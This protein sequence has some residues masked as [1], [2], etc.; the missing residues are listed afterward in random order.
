M[1]LRREARTA[2]AAAGRRPRRRWGQHFLCDPRVV[3][4][5]VAL[6]E[7]DPESAVLEI[8]PGLGALSD[9]LVEVAGTVHLVEIDPVLAER[10]RARYRTS[11]HVRVVEADVLGVSLEDVLGETR[12]AVAVSNLPYNV[13]TPVLFRLLAWRQRLPRAVLMLQ[14]EVADRITAPPGGRI[15]G[16]LGVMIQT[17]GDVES[18]FTVS[19]ASFHP[20]P[21]V[22]ST[23]LRVRWLPAPREPVGDPVLHDRV[24]HAAFGTRRKMLRNALAPLARVR[25]LDATGLA[26][27]LRAAEIDGQARAETLAVADFARLARAF[28]AP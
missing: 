13:S 20:P 15:R 2:L 5:I 12:E 4:R 16:A 17:Y 21:Q 23:V 11:S 26:G 9:A 22:R 28:E 10:L 7:V 19:P 27:V 14:R 24:V 25:G 6:A 1:G 18:A 8:G 3:Q